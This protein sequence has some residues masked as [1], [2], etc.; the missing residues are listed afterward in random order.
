MDKLFDKSKQRIVYIEKAAT[1]EFWDDHWGHNNLTKATKTN[2]KTFVTTVTK[3]YLPKGSRILEGGCGVGNH[4]F[5]LNE[6]GYN[7]TGIDF[8]PNTVSSLNKIVPELDIRVGDVRYLDFESDMFDGYWSL[9]L[10]EHFWN[11][12]DDILKEMCRVIKKNGILFLTFPTFSFL[13]Q[14]KAKMNAY[15]T[16]EENDTEPGGFY[17]FALSREKTINKFESNGFELLNMY[18]LDALKGI[19][20][21]INILKQPFQVIYNSNNLIYKA[22]RKAI[23]AK[24]LSKYCGHSTLLI[25]RYLNE[26]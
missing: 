15:P 22:L 8:A 4:V 26:N 18:G 13:R 10:I 11:G 14:M 7:V 9:G 3:R 23:N 5:A 6:Q 2:K 21:E 12:Y 17:Q 16:L 24:L 19:K 20:D 25:L 1:E